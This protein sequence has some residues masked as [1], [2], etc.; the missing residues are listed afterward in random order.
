MVRLQG[1]RIVRT[2]VQACSATFVGKSG[3]F[4]LDQE[5]ARLLSISIVDNDFFAPRGRCGVPMFF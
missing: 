4:E 5:Y 2:A 1:E 3:L